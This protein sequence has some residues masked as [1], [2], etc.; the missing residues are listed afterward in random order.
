MKEIYRKGYWKK[1]TN[2]RTKIYY[3]LNLLAQHTHTHIY[4]LHRAKKHEKRG[5]RNELSNKTICLNK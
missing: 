5:M 3:A 4:I 2:E 1:Q